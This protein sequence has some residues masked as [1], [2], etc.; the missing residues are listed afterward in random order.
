MTL[1]RDSLLT[2]PFF[3]FQP[4]A[5]CRAALFRAYFAPETGE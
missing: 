5:V 1:Y 4:G 2:F 3:P